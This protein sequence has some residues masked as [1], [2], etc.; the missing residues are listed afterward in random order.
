MNLSTNDEINPK[1]LLYS[2]M[3]AGVTIIIVGTGLIPVLGSQMDE[4]LKKLSV[5]P[6]SSAAMTYFGVMSLILGIVMMVIYAWVHK[7]FETTSGA[8]I[9]IALFFWFF[10][11]FWSN[12]ALVAYGFMSLKLAAMGTVYGLLELVLAG[13]VGAKVYSMQEQRRVHNHA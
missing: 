13:A 12:A 2:G 10:T 4:A 11:Y 7:N 3:S 9:T 1:S 6:L 8:V 5:P